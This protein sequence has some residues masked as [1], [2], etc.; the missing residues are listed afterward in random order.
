MLVLWC[1]SILG[2]LSYWWASSRQQGARGSL[3]ITQMGKLIVPDVTQLSECQITTAQDI[4]NEFRDLELKPSYKADCDPNRAR[5]DHA[6]ICTLLGLSEE[7][8]EASRLL[9]GKWCAEPSV[10]GGRGRVA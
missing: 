7:V 3:T 5:L 9:A 6:V 1:N 4:F 2:L 8:Y 10:H